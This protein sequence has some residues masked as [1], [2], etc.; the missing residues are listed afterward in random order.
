MIRRPLLVSILVAGLMTGG[1]VLAQDPQVPPQ[2]T[3]PVPAPDPVGDVLKATPAPVQPPPAPVATPSETPA[4]VVVAPPAKSE[5]ADDEKDDEK[6]AEPAPKRKAEAPAPAPDR[7][8]RRPIAVIQAIDKITAETMTFEVEV[9]GRPVRF[10]GSLIFTARACE[11]S[12]SD[13]LVD[14]AVAFVEVSVQPRGVSRDTGPREIFKGWMFASAPAVSSL[15]HPV[16]DAWVVG[17][18]A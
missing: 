14:D 16:Y 1:V 9:G 17:C 6:A 18:R 10:K 5:K 3:A 11:V 13:E 8:Q 4:P 12:A 15:E 2:E 7:R